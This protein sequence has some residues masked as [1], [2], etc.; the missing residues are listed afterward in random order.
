MKK[1]AAAAKVREPNFL[2]SELAEL[3]EECARVLLLLQQLGKAR[4][5]GR[6]CSDILGELSATVLHLHAHT[7]GLDDQ[8]DDL[9]SE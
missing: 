4:A 5:A 2:E 3:G 7:K 1:A 8:I 6:D 9:A